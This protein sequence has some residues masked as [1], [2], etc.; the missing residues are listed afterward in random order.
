MSRTAG[1]LCALLL[2]SAL[3]GCSPAMEQPGTDNVS[4][5]LVSVSKD[6]DRVSIETPQARETYLWDS[7]TRFLDPEEKELPAA[8]FSR[9]YA[10]RGVFLALEGKRVL[11]IQ[12]VDF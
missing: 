6:P 12:R 2:L 8:A 9:R 4:G 10:G 11:F 1:L 7:E 3:S 5:V